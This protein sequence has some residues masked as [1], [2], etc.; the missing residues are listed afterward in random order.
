MKKILVLA[1]CLAGCATHNVCN[2]HSSW[3][4]SE[5]HKL[6]VTLD[7]VNAAVNSGSMPEDVADTL[8][9]MIVRDRESIATTEY[10]VYHC[11]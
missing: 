10:D 1:I 3:Y 11:N 6:D 9:N 2:Q 7:S 8:R 4:I 5:N